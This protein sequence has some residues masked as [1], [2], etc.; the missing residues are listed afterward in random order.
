M[1]MSV[2][3][4]AEKAFSLQTDIQC[5]QQLLKRTVKK[6]MQQLEQLIVTHP[7]ALQQQQAFDSQKVC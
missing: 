4:L 2:L 6:A 7:A 1:F 3:Q 5:Q